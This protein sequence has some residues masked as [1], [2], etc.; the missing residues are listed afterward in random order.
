MPHV[1]SLRVCEAE[2]EALAW[3]LDVV[4]NH[5]VGSESTD[6]SA[7]G[8]MDEHEQVRNAIKVLMEVGLFVERIESVHQ[9][10]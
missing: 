2:D 6:F 1:V 7:V 3:L 10:G 4:L 9:S 8:E 5:W